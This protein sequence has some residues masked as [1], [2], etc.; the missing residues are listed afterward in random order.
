VNPR[1]I[2]H[3]FLVLLVAGGVSL[4][5][6]VGP[7]GK[8]GRSSAPELTIGQAPELD[9]HTATNSDGD[10]ES[11]AIAA[12][13]IEPLD[14]AVPVASDD[15]SITAA[16]VNIEPLGEAVPLVLHQD[17]LSVNTVSAA[18]TVGDVLAEEGIVVEPGDYLFPS[19]GSLVTAGTHIYIYRARELFLSVGGDTTTVHS[20]KA[21][22]AE[23]LDEAD[24]SLDALDRVEPALDSPVE[25]GLTIRVVRVREEY[26]TVEEAIPCPVVY[27]DDPTMDM[28]RYLVLDWGADGLIHREYRAV[29]EDGQEI[30]RELLNEWEQPASEQIIAQGTKPVNL[31]ETPQGPL[32]YS[33]SLEMYATWYRPASCGRSPESPWYGI[34]ATGVQVQRGIVAVDPNVIPLGSR[35]Y[36]PGYGQ[37]IAADTGSAVVGNIIDLGFADYEV[38]DW[39]SGWTT[40]YVLE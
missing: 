14:E 32:R 27:Q 34:A 7:A 37:G 36:V 13:D 19:S 15:E 30:E 3:L 33:H 21:T 31:V 29:Y 12:V 38:P 20:R 23:V 6:L 8:R 35:V 9:G 28:G 10:D 11:I 24:I 16:A 1:H 39:H 4:L 26:E 18:P 5:F 17:G 2:L 40:V 22:V 25:D